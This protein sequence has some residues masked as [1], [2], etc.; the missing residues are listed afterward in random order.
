MLKEGGV[1]EGRERAQIEE[2]NAEGRKQCGKG[3][4]G[5]EGG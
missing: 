1:T 5:W 4:T 2:C 3:I